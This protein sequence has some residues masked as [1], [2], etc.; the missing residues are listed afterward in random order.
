MKIRGYVIRHRYVS[1]QYSGRSHILVKGGY[2]HED[3]EASIMRILP[4]FMYKSEAAAKAAATK[5][6]KYDTNE[7]VYEVLAV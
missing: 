1:G 3:S 6:A 7:C 4:D 2:V 5:F